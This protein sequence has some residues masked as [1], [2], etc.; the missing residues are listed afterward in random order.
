MLGNLKGKPS[1]NI[2]LV[3]NENRLLD[4]NENDRSISILITLLPTP[5]LDNLSHSKLCVTEGK[6]PQKSIKSTKNFPP[7]RCKRD[8]IVALR[9][10]M[11]SMQLLFFLNSTCHSGKKPPPSIHLVNL[12]ASICVKVLAIVFTRAIGR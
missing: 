3:L 4:D 10:K 11:L 1:N 5:I 8:C 6:A 7:E 12:S 9:E 2:N